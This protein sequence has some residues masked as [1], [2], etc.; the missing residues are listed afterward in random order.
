[1][2]LQFF[3]RPR[4]RNSTL[5]SKEDVGKEM[6]RKVIGLLNSYEQALDNKNHGKNLI[7]KLPIEG[8]LS[9]QTI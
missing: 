4:E 7:Q 8:R 3:V 2:R 5:P 6:I 9:I 1:M